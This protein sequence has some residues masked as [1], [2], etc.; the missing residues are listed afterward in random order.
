SDSSSI[1]AVSSGRSIRP[2]EPVHAWSMLPPR[3]VHLVQN[4]SKEDRARD[5]PYVKGGR[6]L[7]TPFYQR[8]QQWIQPLSKADHRGVERAGVGRI[9]NPS[10]QIEN[11]PY[12]T[13]S[14]PSVN[15]SN[16]RIRTKRT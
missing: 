3:A 6:W 5:A 2:A 12:A 11:S 7:I 13:V 16:R 9:F 15:R 8:K 4:R 10:G 14:D 1:F